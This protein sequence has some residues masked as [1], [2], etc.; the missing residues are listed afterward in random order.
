MEE[1]KDRFD[2]RVTV[3]WIGD[4]EADDGEDPSDWIG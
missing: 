4:E 3:S 1:L 2:T